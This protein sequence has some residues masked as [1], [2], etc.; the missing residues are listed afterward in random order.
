MKNYSIYVVTHIHEKFSAV[1]QSLEPENAELF[2]GRGYP[3][4]SKLINTCVAKCSTETI[5]I[6]SHKVLPKAEH[7]QKILTLLEKGYAFVGLN[8]FRFFGFKKE[9]FRRI[10]PLDERYL[11]GGFEDYD[12]FVRLAEADLAVYVTQE[13]YC[14]HGP[15][16]WGDYSTAIKNWQAKWKH[17]WEPNNPAPACVKRMFPEEKYD[18][19]FGP[20]VPTNYL[21]SK[22]HTYLWRDPHVWVFFKM[23]I[24]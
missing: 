17:F 20:S 23:K 13:V 10:G 8:N 22:E 6:A 19:D 7:I 18:Y 12:F 9:L 5:I 11:G 2:D 21:S 3:S 16:S 24:L 1:A 4:F 15:S 14:N